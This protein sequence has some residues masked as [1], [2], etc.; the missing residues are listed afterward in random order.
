MSKIQKNIIV[1]ILV[2]VSFSLG[3]SLKYLDGSSTEIQNL[4][5]QLTMLQNQNNQLQ[6]Q[7][8]ELKGFT[9][10]ASVLNETEVDHCKFKCDGNWLIPINCEIKREYCENGC[11]D[12]S[13]VNIKEVPS[14]CEILNDEQCD[15]ENPCPEGYYCS[16]YAG[17]HY[18]CIP[19]GCPELCPG[20]Q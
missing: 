9:S 3:Y 17:P 19:E 5:K 2:L 12:G 7:I 8:D 4:Q 11:K 13:C 15:N 10:N 18:R 14:N 6:K 16:L 20:C 1:V